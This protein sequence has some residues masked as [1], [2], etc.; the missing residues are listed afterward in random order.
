MD[1]MMTVL[2]VLLGLFVAANFALD[3]L[4][5]FCDP[6]DYTSCSFSADRPG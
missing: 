5:D 2:L 3:R 1:A 6:L 4:N